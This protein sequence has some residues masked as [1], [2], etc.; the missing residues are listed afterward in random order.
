MKLLVN[1]RAPSTRG[2]HRAAWTAWRRF[3][4]E[5]NAKTSDCSEPLMTLFVAWLSKTKRLTHGSAR[6]YVYGVCAFLSLTGH[7]VSLAEM[8]RVVL[9]LDGYKR[10]SPAAVRSD[11][12]RVTM[13]VLRRLQPHVR[14][15]A[16]E[17]SVWA[18]MVTATQGLFRLGELAV[19]R[20]G[21]PGMTKRSLRLSGTRAA[22]VFLPDSKTD[23]LRRGVGVLLAAI[24][25]QLCAPPL[26]E[27]LHRRSAEDSPLFPVDG[28]AACKQD[29]LSLLGEL[30]KRASIVVARK[31]KGH[32]FRQGGAQSLFDAGVSIEDIKIFGRWKSDAFRAY[33]EMSLARIEHCHARMAAAQESTTRWDP[34]F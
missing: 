20:A 19:P 14:N 1:S 8:P 28:R 16:R 10:L 26:L 11:K 21:L 25:G 34:D 12:F 23:F 7:T 32:S 13:S 6:Q 4:R 2:K 30:L 18:L 5:V 31:L 22:S 15:T 3:C 9:A 29:V 24:P 27:K 17:Q 33:I